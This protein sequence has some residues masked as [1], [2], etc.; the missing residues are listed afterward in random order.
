M[1]VGGFY[2]HDL[3]ISKQ[4]WGWADGLLK[5]LPLRIHYLGL[6]VCLLFDLGRLRELRERH[7]LPP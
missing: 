2:G 1:N 3:H 5:E 6:L 4:L 7:A